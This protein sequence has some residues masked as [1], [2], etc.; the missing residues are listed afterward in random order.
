MYS[1]GL[2]WPVLGALPGQSAGRVRACFR[3]FEYSTYSRP[4][5]APGWPFSC[6]GK[7]RQGAKGRQRQA[8]AQAAARRSGT[9][10]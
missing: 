9:P 7:A 10:I 6:Q 8:T 5:L 2:F 1:S 3:P 4:W